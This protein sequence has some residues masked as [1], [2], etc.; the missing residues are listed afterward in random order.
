M[1]PYILGVSSGAA[2]GA[3]L[4]I[5]FP[6]A[7]P[8]AFDI[9]L[10]NTSDAPVEARMTGWDVEPGTWELVQDGKA[11]RVS[12]ARGQELALRLPPMRPTIVRMRRA[13]PK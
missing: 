6:H 1:E 8:E 4:A 2:C 7:T 3:A 11:R 10:F 12:F 9:E 5:L 13:G